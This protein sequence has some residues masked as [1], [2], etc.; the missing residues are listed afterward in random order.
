M[1]ELTR[2]KRTALAIA[3]AAGAAALGCAGAASTPKA[4]PEPVQA[5]PLA[6][7]GGRPVVFLPIQYGT[8]PDWVSWEQPL[9]PTI[10]F[11]P[12]LDDSIAASLGNRGLNS[13]TFAPAITASARRNM[14]M[15]ADPHALA[16]ESLRRLVKA[17]DD[18][19]SEPLASQI[20]SLVA[21]R[22]ARYV[23]L[24]AIIRFENRGAG[25]RALVLFYLIDTRTSRIRWSGQVAS[26]VSRNFSTIVRSLAERLAD[27]VVAR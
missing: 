27:L 12:A 18:P 1:G 2:L 11:L 6:A 15:T 23:I 19:V 26:D 14:G 4:Q 10:Q 3:A 22:D 8:Y 16:S 20:R 21:L 24:P 17:G 13:W 9:P 7:M 5:M 25:T